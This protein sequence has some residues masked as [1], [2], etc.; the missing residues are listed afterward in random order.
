MES[1][2]ATEFKDRG[3]VKWEGQ[4]ESFLQTWSLSRVL[5]ELHV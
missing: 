2:E 4:I 3:F 1:V 5:H